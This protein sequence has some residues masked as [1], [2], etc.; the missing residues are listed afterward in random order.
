MVFLLFDASTHR[1]LGNTILSRSWHGKVILLAVLVP[2]LFVFIQRYLDRPTLEG[3]VLLAAAG[4]AAVG[5]DH[6]RLPCADHCGRLLRSGGDPLTPT[7]GR[8]SPGDRRL[9]ARGSGGRHGGRGAH[10]R[11]H[12][13]LRSARPLVRSVLDEGL[14]AFVAVG[15]ILLAPSLI[16]VAFRRGWPPRRPFSSASC[17]FLS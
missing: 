6:R 9:P 17:S 3:L 14:L 2:L 4:V 12:R 16:S 11:R 10:R 1:A 7:G 15:A 8:R 5:L 13:L